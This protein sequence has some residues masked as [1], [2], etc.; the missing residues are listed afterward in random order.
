MSIQ[1]QANDEEKVPSG[2]QP[3]LRP[4]NTMRT[5]ISS[6]RH[7][8]VLDSDNGIVLQDGEQKVEA[9]FGY[10][11]QTKKYCIRYENNESVTW[12]FEDQL[13][14]T[15][16]I[17]LTQ[18]RENG[19]PVRD[20]NRRWRALKG[21]LT[22]SQF[23]EQRDTVLTGRLVATR[24]LS[25]E[26]EISVPRQCAG[27][28]RCLATSV[29]NLTV[30]LCSERQKQDLATMEQNESFL[31]AKLSDD[32]FPVRMKAATRVDHVGPGEFLIAT[33]PAHIDGLRVFQDGSMHFFTCDQ[34]ISNCVLTQDH[35]YVQ[36]ILSRPFLRVIELLRP[37]IAK[38]GNMQK[39]K[40]ARERKE[41][42]KLAKLLN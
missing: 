17:W 36:A 28:L 20:Q 26:T 34:R 40:R 12:V 39:R 19:L 8:I 25:G 3:N 15:K 24:G 22:R 5:S 32:N 10:D 35:P 37:D 7:P 27:E 6:Q 33:T 2:D 18:A 30:S 42:N 23:R 29:L 41:A 1:D 14:D 9:F 21:A 31:A 38:H 13:Q 4:A 16:T 11:S